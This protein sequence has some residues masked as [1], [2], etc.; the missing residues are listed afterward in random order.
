MV[1]RSIFGAYPSAAREHVT[2]QA[3]LEVRVIVCGEGDSCEGRAFKS[4]LGHLLRPQMHHN[5][6]L[7][8]ASGCTTGDHGWRA[9]PLPAPLSLLRPVPLPPPPIT[10]CQRMHNKAITAQSDLSSV[11]ELGEP[12]R[13]PFSA[14]TPPQVLQLLAI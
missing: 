2:Y 4:V 14:S 12:K 10:S 6:T 1:S 3:A 9:A 11:M 7:S 8:S 13:R 5:V